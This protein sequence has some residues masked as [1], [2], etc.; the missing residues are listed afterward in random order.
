MHILVKDK[1]QAEKIEKELKEGADFAKIAEKESI[2][3][4]AKKNKGDLGFIYKGQ[5][6]PEFEKQAFSMEPGDISPPIKTQF[7]YHI[8]KV[9]EKSPRTV[10][11]FED[12]KDQIELEL[13]REKALKELEKIKK[14]LKEKA[15]IE[16][17]APEY[18][19]AEAYEKET[20][21]PMPTEKVTLSPTS[22]PEAK[23]TKTP[24]KEIKLTP[25][26]TVKEKTEATPESKTKMESIKEE[27]SPTP[28]A[29]EEIKS[30][31]TSTPEVTPKSSEK[32]PTSTLTPVNTQT[33]VSSE[34]P[35]K[36]N[37]DKLAPT[38]EP[39]V[40]Q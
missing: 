28:T 19:Q 3:P 1:K 32:L 9:L 40:S 25:T 15:K 2:D 6:V 36:T 30:V 7:G 34:T 39:T 10:K 26:P 12:V 21:T 17:F 22:V 35:I 11:K 4:S 27:L 38:P 33:P 29:K 23:S 18:K 20:P 37:E 13:K 24:E 31:E 5:T 8:I 16:I 14:E